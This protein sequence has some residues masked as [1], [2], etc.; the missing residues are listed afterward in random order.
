MS[1]FIDSSS[2]WVGQNQERSSKF[3]FLSHTYKEISLCKCLCQCRI[4]NRH[5][6]YL[7]VRKILWRRKCLP[8]LVFLPGKLHGQG[9]KE[10]DRTEQ[11]NTHNRATEMERGNTPWKESF[12]LMLRIGT[13]HLIPEWPPWRRW[14]GPPLN[15]S[16]DGNSLPPSSGCK[17]LC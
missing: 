4:C 14:G 8:T 9:S 5:G 6:F 2:A 1:A 16:C 10:L 13:A 3:L 17:L 12:A 11:L 7:W 15:T